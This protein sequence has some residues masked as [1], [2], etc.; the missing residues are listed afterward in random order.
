MSIRTH[1]AYLVTHI[2]KAKKAYYSGNCIMPDY[3]YDAIEEKL[4][5]LDPKHPVLSSVGYDSDYDWWIT[6]YESEIQN[7]KGDHNE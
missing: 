5:Q 1:V 6:H 7:Y 2:I 4:R 3:E